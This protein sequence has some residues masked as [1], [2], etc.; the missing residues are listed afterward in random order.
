M[1]QITMF[2]TGKNLEDLTGYKQGDSISG[3]Q[4]LNL[5]DKNIVDVLVTNNTVWLDIKGKKFR[6]R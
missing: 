1:Y 3:E 4:L 5:I 2:F 6:Q